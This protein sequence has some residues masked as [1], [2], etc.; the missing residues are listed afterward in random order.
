MK[1]FFIL[2]AVACGILIAG[3]VCDFKEKDVLSQIDYAT[4]H[5]HKDK[6][7]GLQKALKELRDHCKDNIVLS[8]LELDVQKLENKVIEAKS[9]ITQAQAKGKADRIKKAEMKLRLIETELASKKDELQRMQD[10]A[11]GN[12]PQPKS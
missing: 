12:N 6:I 3:P 9:K 1:K 4:K 2:S 11:K 7:S 8:E 10:L 5:N